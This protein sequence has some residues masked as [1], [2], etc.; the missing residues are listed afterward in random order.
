MAHKV[1]IVS[2]H[3]ALA[4]GSTANKAIIEEYKRLDPSVQV[5]DLG[6]L[7]PDFKIDAKAEQ[8]AL[9]QADVIVFEFPVYWYQVPALMKKWFEDV[10]THGF[11]YGTGGDKLKDRVMLLSCTTGSPAG[12]YTPQG[13][14]SHPLD[15]YL[16]N[17]E[18]TAKLCGMKYAKPL[19]AY[20]ML[21]IPG[22]MDEKAKAA[23]IEKAKAHAKALKSKIDA[24]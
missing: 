17:Y 2:G 4:S 18:Q 11:A 10:F 6:A 1:L 16:N 21:Y 20:G 14:N 19:I 7:Y 13:P 24:L 8:E 3:P 22:V 23:V 5:R 9:T 12:A 15:F